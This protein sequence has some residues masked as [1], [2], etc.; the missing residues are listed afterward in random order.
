MR[1]IILLGLL[2]ALGSCKS[3]KNANCDAYG[4]L[5]SDYITTDQAYLEEQ[6]HLE[7]VFSW[8]SSEKYI[9]VNTIEVKTDRK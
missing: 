6:I 1:L 9:M 2:I 4:G 7:E 3:K 8:V 5:D